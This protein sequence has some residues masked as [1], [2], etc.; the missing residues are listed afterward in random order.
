MDRDPYEFLGPGKEDPQPGRYI[1]ANA[2]R[3][4]MR[5]PARETAR[6]IGREKEARDYARV[7]VSA[8]GSIHVMLSS[9]GVESHRRE[10][11]P[12][13]SHFRRIAIHVYSDVLTQDRS[14]RILLM[15]PEDEQV[16][17]EARWN[18]GEILL[19]PR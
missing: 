1:K 7:L 2:E 16:L 13:R 11:A 5:E 4:G 6:F 12:L 19:A 10:P 3:P 9:A 18:D 15:D 8:D 17:E 14:F